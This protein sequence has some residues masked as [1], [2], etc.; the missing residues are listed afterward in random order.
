MVGVSSRRC[1]PLRVADFKQVSKPGSASTAPLVKVFNDVLWSDLEGAGIFDM[2][3]KSFYPKDLPGRPE[4]MPAD[5]IVAWSIPS[6]T[7][8][9]PGYSRLGAGI[10]SA[11]ECAPSRISG[12]TVAMG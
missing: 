12:V 5:R 11:A 8:S 2:V 7:M 6:T 10:F 4:E 1:F 9:E 3:S